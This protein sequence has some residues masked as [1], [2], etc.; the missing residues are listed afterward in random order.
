MIIEAVLK[1]EGYEVHTAANG[2]AGLD[3][4][5]ELK[6]QLMI[7]DVMMPEM[8]G[9][10]VCYRL[11]KDPDTADIAILML[12]AKG[13]VEGDARASW[14]FAGRVQDRLRGFDMGATEFLTKPVKAKDLVQ[15]VRAVLWAGGIAV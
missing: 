12:T 5:R 6:P 3:K 13:D 7:L 1:K 8:N 14:Q 2:K 11:K 4:A 9:Y 15:K 10:E